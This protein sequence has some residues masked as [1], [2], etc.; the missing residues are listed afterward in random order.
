MNRAWST[1]PTRADVLW[2][3]GVACPGESAA[4]GPLATITVGIGAGTVACPQAASSR[5]KRAAL[6]Q[7]PHA[8]ANIFIIES[9]ALQLIQAMSD[10][11]GLEQS[12][13]EIFA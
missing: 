1:H 11:R 10:F 7:P 4:S 13:L 12:E 6:T 9:G 2:E 5:A 8:L 3:S